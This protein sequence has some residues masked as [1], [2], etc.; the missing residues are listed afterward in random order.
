[1][2]REWQAKFDLK[3]L[4]FQRGQIA[5]ISHRPKGAKLALAQ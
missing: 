2:E 4:Q 1:M 5:D 3:N